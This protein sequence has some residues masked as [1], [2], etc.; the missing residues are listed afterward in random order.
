[1]NTSLEQDDFEKPTSSDSG[2]SESCEL[3]QEVLTPQRAVRLWLNA[4]LTLTRA[5]QE[6]H[7]AIFALDG[8]EASL[9]RY[10]AARSELDSAEAWALRVA[11][12]VPAS[13]TSGDRPPLRGEVRGEA[14]LC[15]RVGSGSEIGTDGDAG[16]GMSG[17]EPTVSG[18]SGPTS[19]PVS[20]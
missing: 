2:A 19:T 6:L 10:A 3:E 14:V 12:T 5:Q 9:D 11:K 17:V 4:S 7:D 1:M 18:Q 15:Q 8:S 16:G 13:A 20:S